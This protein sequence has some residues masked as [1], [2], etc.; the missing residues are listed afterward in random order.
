MSNDKKNRAVSLDLITMM[1]ILFGTLF[2]LSSFEVNGEKYIYGLW[3]GKHSGQEFM[4]RFNIDETCVLS[5]KD[6]A[7][8]STRVLNGNFEMN[9]SKKPVPLSIRNSPSINH[10]LHTIVDFIGDDSIRLAE[11]S[12]RWKVRPISFD[13]NT[14]I[15][16]N[17]VK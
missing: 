13:R 6:N 2:I 9:L 11:F 12:S 3:K 15:N 1:F 4:F 10:P 7:S 8:D 14:S 16:L 17:R 5:F